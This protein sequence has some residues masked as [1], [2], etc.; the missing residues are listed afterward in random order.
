MVS[1]QCKKD[2]IIISL[3]CEHQALTRL[4]ESYE[5]MKL[6]LFSRLHSSSLS[7]LSPFTG[8]WHYTSHIILLVDCYSVTFSP[9]RLLLVLVSISVPSPPSPSIPLSFLHRSVH[10]ST[11]LV[12]VRSG[13]PRRVEW[14]EGWSDSWSPVR[15][16]E[17]NYPSNESHSSSL[18]LSLPSSLSSSTPL[19]KNA[20]GWQLWEKKTKQQQQKKKQGT[21]RS[22]AQLLHS[23]VFS[24]LPPPGPLSQSARSS[25]EMTGNNERRDG[26]KQQDKGR[27]GVIEWAVRGE[28]GG[29]ETDTPML[30]HAETHYH[31]C[32]Q[33]RCWTEGELSVSV[34]VCAS[35]HAY[36][37]VW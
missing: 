31:G 35:M 1:L 7:V 29:K 3:L 34:R 10:P 21:H 14:S 13:R 24:F 37:C 9:P 8:H 18:H 19:R 11:H 5:S 30:A 4:C 22:T 27:R 2:A 15:Q 25:V 6:C 20:P 36:V 17:T 23:V 16:G 32:C 26:G 28:E 33:H 12:E